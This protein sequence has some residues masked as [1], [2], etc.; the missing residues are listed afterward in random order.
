MRGRYYNMVEMLARKN[1]HLLDHK[2]KMGYNA[3]MLSYELKDWHLMLLILLLG[4]DPNARLGNSSSVNNDDSNPNLL[5]DTV[6]LA[7]LKKDC[8]FEVVPYVMLL[9]KFGAEPGISDY[10]GENSF[11]IIASNSKT[12]LNLAFKLFDCLPII[13]RSI[14]Y[15]KNHSGQAPYDVSYQP[16]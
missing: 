5:T 6:L 9:L 10:D 12:N 15:A 8:S 4:A 7:I 3:L 16:F 14:V 1:H 13:N 11:H 2:N